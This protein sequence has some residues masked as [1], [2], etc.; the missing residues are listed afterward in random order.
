MTPGSSL[1]MCTH[2]IPYSCNLLHRIFADFCCIG[3]IMAVTGES[4]TRCYVV[5]VN[6]ARH[7]LH[8]SSLVIQHEWPQHLIQ[9]IVRYW[10]TMKTMKANA[11][12]GMPHSF[13]IKWRMF[14]HCIACF[15]VLKSNKVLCARL[16]LPKVATSPSVP[17]ECQT[18]NRFGHIINGVLVEKATPSIMKLRYIIQQWGQ[19]VWCCYYF[20]RFTPSR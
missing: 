5:R 11:F 14:G 4:L 16:L 20:W 9:L 17:T 10:Y 12:G 13:L 1:I 18:V 7:L 19:N 6:L 2:S 3:R 15:F 8:L